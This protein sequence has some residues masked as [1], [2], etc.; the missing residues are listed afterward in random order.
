MTKVY[1]DIGMDPSTVVWASARLAPVQIVTWGHPSTTGLSSIDYY[2]SSEYFHYYPM[3]SDP[4]LTPF[5]DE[6]GDDD[7]KQTIV[8]QDFF[9]EQLVQFHSLN[10]LFQK[11]MNFD[12][13]AVFGKNKDYKQL[14]VER[15]KEFHQMIGKYL[16]AQQKIKETKGKEALLQLNREKLK[17]NF[18]TPTQ[19]NN[20]KTKVET[21]KV[22]YILCPQYLPKF[23]PNFD[24]I[25]TEILL[26]NDWKS[27]FG[28]THDDNN[29][30]NNPAEPAPKVKLLLLNDADKKLMWKRTLMNRWSQE[31]SDRIL[32][33]S[34]SSDSDIPVVQ[35][36]KFLDEF[37][38]WLP[39]LSPEEYLLMNALGD[40]MIDPF[41]FGGGVTTLESFYM[42][43]PVITLPDQ[44]NVPQLTSGMLLTLAER[45]MDDP[46]RRKEFLKQLVVHSQE[47]Y[48]ENIKELI[49]LDNNPKMNSVEKRNTT[50]EGLSSL[51]KTICDVHELFYWD[52]LN[53]NEEEYRPFLSD[54]FLRESVEE[55]NSFFQKISAK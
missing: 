5:S 45:G 46:T 48:L 7:S 40:M 31:L 29:N 15:N 49:E 18:L 36:K 14:L 10:F 4:M 55:W 23:H 52:L 28:I 42:C 47:E 3:S 43:T 19:D 30:H 2:L 38:V 41:P 35:I 21:G 32:S 22:F 39:S 34:S 17:N 11:P 33:S 16:K 44:Q 53:E 6:S 26:L 12:F 37:L 51:R 24:H 27:F 9:A 50:G 1:L 25:L 13:T 8:P 54:L 20:D